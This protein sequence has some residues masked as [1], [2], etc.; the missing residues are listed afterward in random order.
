MGGDHG[1]ALCSDGASVGL[2]WAEERPYR[3]LNTSKSDFRSIV[4]VAREFGLTP[5]ALRFYEAKGLLAPRREGPVRRYD[6]LQRDRLALLVKAKNLGF[7]L[8][9]VRE[10]IGAPDSPVAGN[11]LDM[12]RRQCVAQIRLLEG[13]KREIEAALVEL[14]RTYSAFYARLP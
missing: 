5:R 12:T 14:R 10:M 6:R 13:R 8:A 1:A 7:T 2:S 3:Y 4:E 11:A 9:E